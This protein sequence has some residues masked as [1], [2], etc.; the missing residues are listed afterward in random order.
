M[1]IEQV[2]LKAPNAG[3]GSLVHTLISECPPLDTNSMYCNLLQTHHFAATSVAAIHQSRLVGFISGYII[4][5]RP[6]TL[7][8][9]QVAVSEAARGI[10]L[11]S[12]MLNDILQRPECIHV[13]HLETSITPSNTGSWKLFE[14][15]A[16][17]LDAPLE[18]SVLFDR[19]RHLNDQH[20]TE[21]LVRIGPFNAEQL[22]TLNAYITAEH[23]T[24]KE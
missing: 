3:L 2:T 12:R 1:N 20:D 5:Q 24:A 4:P 7:F 11:A 14:G 19:F 23:S 6:D 13:N 10:G 17:K 9:W 15:L 8:I 18:K 21:H 22:A 16:R